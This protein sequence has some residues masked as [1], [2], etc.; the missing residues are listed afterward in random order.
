METNNFNLLNVEDVKKYVDNLSM[1]RPL[2]IRTWCSTILRKWLYVDTNKR[3]VRQCVDIK[4]ANSPLFK[5]L[6]M[7]L[8]DSNLKAKDYNIF[9]KVDVK[10]LPEWAVT[11]LARNELYYW[12]TP[13]KDSE[14]TVNFKHWLDYL[15]TLPIKR[16]L[17]MTVEHVVDAVAAWD[18]QLAKQKLISS[19]SE[20]VETVKVK[21]LQAYPNL[22]LVKLVTKDAYAN[23]GA[24]MKHCVGSYYGRKDTIIYSLRDVE[25][26]RPAAT[27]E[28]H[29][30]KGIKYIEQIRGFSNRIVDL[31]IQSAIDAIAAEFNWVEAE[32]DEEDEDYE[33][34]EDDEEED[35]E[36]GE[37]EDDDDDDDGGVP[38]KE[39]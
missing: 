33:D 6:R 26:V 34:G 37:D 22:Y 5:M 30:W 4:E 14:D 20:G 12:I 9:R 27:I 19:L 31:N 11:A 13:D 2:H 21:A 3:F 7:L 29:T 16:Q 35:D 25:E 15:D 8:R 1:N 24:I 28:I 17:S 10:D 18:K 38:Y 32:D 23:E 36:D 39:R